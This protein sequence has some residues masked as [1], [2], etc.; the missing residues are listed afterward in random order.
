MKSFKKFTSVFLVLMLSFSIFMSVNVNAT[1]TFTVK[2]Q[3]TGMRGANSTSTEVIAEGTVPYTAGMTAFDAIKAIAISSGQ[4]DI[5]EVIDGVTYHNQ[6]LLRWYTTNWGDYISA[7]KVTGH[8]SNNKFFGANGSAISSTISNG[9]GAYFKQSNL[10]ATETALGYSTNAT[11]VDPDDAVNLDGYVSE[12]DYNRFSGWM[13]L[14]DGSTNNNGIGTV[15]TSNNS[16]VVLDFSMMMGL[17]LG[18][19]SY[20]QNSGGSWVFVNGWN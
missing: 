2:I 19:D 20:V 12:K 14:I 5:T 17:D 4:T 13:L 9:R 6:G 8:S 1:D 11:W 15:L 3:M 16:T 10:N 7:I 18:Q